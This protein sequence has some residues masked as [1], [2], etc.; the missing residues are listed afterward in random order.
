MYEVLFPVWSDFCFQVET[1]IRALAFQHMSCFLFS[2]MSCLFI[3][4]L[5]WNF[6]LINN[7][8]VQSLARVSRAEIF[9]ARPPTPLCR[10]AQL[11]YYV[12]LLSSLHRVLFSG[13]TPSP[14]RSSQVYA[15]RLTV[16]PT[17]CEKYP[18]CASECFAY[19][20]SG[21]FFLYCPNTYASF[22]MLRV[23]LYATRIFV[24]ARASHLR[25]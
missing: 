12:R 11:L 7:F 25:K 13:H 9:L 5:S 15:G 10:V 16:M 1:K 2:R 3:G 19:I 18:C 8:T 6:A 22:Y 17:Q 24:E 4:E 23:L 21:E 14:W 20:S